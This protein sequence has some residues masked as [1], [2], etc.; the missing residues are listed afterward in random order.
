MAVAETIRIAA[1]SGSALS[2]C[3]DVPGRG[4]TLGSSDVPNRG[5]NLGS[6]DNPD[7]TANQANPLGN[8]PNMAGVF[9]IGINADL[10]PYIGSYM[11]ILFTV[12]GYGHLHIK[13][14]F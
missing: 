14:V 2:R 1:G 11:R 7:V 8:Q 4:W 12:P 6:T 13:K 9:A 10:P 3:L 5:W